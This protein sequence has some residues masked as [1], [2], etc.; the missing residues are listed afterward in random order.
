MLNTYRASKPVGYEMLALCPY[1][2]GYKKLGECGDLIT[3]KWSTLM[4]LFP[5]KVVGSM[6]NILVGLIFRMEM[7]TQKIFIFLFGHLIFMP[8]WLC[9]PRKCI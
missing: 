2:G 9:L 1:M 6:T 5:Y 7:R 8:T 3:E 4:S